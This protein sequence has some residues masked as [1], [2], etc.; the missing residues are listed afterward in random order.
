MHESEVALRQPQHHDCSYD[1]PFD[2]SSPCDF[3]EQNPSHPV[4][5]DDAKDL[6]NLPNLATLLSSKFQTIRTLDDQVP[7]GACCNP[8]FW[9]V[10][11]IDISLGTYGVVFSDISDPIPFEKDELFSPLIGS[12]HMA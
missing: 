7:T 4:T 2:A 12:K 3:T 8:N 5:V 10:V 6:L 9:S 11:S 1:S